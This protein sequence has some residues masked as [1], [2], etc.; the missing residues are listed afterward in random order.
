LGASTKVIN[1]KK[2]M[3]LTLGAL[4]GCFQVMFMLASGGMGHGMSNAAGLVRYLYFGYG[5]MFFLFFPVL[6]YAAYFYVAYYKQHKVGIWFAIAHYSI[7][8]VFIG[9]SLVTRHLGLSD[10]FEDRKFSMSTTVMDITWFLF[11]NLL[12]FRRIFAGKAQLAVK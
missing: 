1:F 12:Y 11:L 10:I 8:L 5:E 9:H 4:L 3:I 2:A 6:Q 7:A